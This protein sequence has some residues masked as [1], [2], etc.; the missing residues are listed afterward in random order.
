MKVNYLGCCNAFD[1]ILEGMY[2]NPG[3][4]KIQAS[5]ILQD[6]GNLLEVKLDIACT[7]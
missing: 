6:A 5:Q 3:A 7:M 1:P 4:L 2:V